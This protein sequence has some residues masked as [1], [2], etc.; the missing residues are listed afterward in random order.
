MLKHIAIIMDGNGRWAEARGLTRSQGHEAGSQQISVVSRAAA[1]LGVKVL[2]LYAFSTENWKRP[3][4]EINFLMG[5]ISRY[6]IEKLP[7]MMENGIRLRTIGR[8]SELPFTSRRSVEKTVA[9]TA[10]NERL[11]LNIALNYGG[12]AE[13]VDA[14]NS[15]L[16][17]K[18]KNSKVSEQEFQQHLYAPDLPDP[19][20]LIRTG[21]EY[22]LSNFL[23]WELS[24]TEFYVTNTCWPDFGAEELQKAIAA[25][26]QR[27]RRF[28]AIEAE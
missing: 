2:T 27:N 1:E 10:G 12:R 22:R 20:L 4:S 23:L 5:L 14:V 15:L 28:G 6:S 17:S 16:K 3:V 25:F 11:T 21:G 9:A 24:Y 18:R 19:D 8:L 7:E 26:T 13:I